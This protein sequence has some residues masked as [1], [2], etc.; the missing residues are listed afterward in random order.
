MERLELLEKKVRSVSAEI[1]ALQIRVLSESKPWYKQAA[2][3]IALFALIFS[4]GSTLVANKR[5]AE[6]DERAMRQ[7]LRELVLQLVQQPLKG[8]E[9]NEKY[10]DQPLFCVPPK[11]S[12][13]K[14]STRRGR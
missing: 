4:F 1:D 13:M 8:I 10:K 3:L 11:W 5:A 9:L 12:Q 7:E 6:L 14:R 2:T